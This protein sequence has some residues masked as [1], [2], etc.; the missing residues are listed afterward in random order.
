M[1]SSGRFVTEHGGHDGRSRGRDREQA[2]PAFKSDY[3]P[4]L[5][6]AQQ[7]ARHVRVASRRELHSSEG[8]VGRGVKSR[9]HLRAAGERKV[10]PAVGAG[11]ARAL[12]GGACERDR[13]VQL[14]G[15]LRI[16]QGAV[17]GRK[18]EFAC[19]PLS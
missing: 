14:N 13:R 11:I 5:C 3:H 2:V 17:P 10:R 7:L 12:G 8:V 16:A 9:T 18:V 19:E 4:A 15:L 1:L 6:E